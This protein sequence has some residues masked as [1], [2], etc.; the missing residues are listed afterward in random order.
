MKRRIDEMSYNSNMVQFRT[1][2]DTHAPAESISAEQA[3]LHY[4]QAYQRLYLRAPRDLRA[5][6]HD[7]VIVN[8]ARMKASE[9]EHLTRQL[10]LE[11]Q[12]S[13]AQKKSLVMKLLNF[14]KQ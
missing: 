3:M 7:W 14:F 10:Q 1:P 11:Y 12:Q 2:T 9:L 13:Q 5:L 8:G 6:D 4:A